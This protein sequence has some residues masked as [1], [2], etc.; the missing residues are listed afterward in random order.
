MNNYTILVVDDELSVLN[1]IYRLF[2]KDG[3]QILRCDKPADALN[4][5]K[6][7][8]IHIIISDYRMPD[9]DGVTFLREAM[10]L[11]PDTIRIILSGYADSSA[12]ISAINDGGIYKFLTKP[13]E[14]DMLRAEV[15]HALEFYDLR[16]VNKQLLK[17]IVKQNNELIDK[18]NLLTE[19]IE[20]I[21]ESIVSTVE[22]LNYLSREKY[23]AI[24]TNCEHLHNMS[25]KVGKKLG[26]NETALNHLHIATKLHDIGNI[27]VDCIILRKN[28]PLTRE[29]R[30]KVEKHPI[31]GASI[32]SFL[33]GFDEVSRIIRHHHEC[34]DGTGY[35]DGLKGDEIPI[36][37]R[38]I[39]II[40]V[41]DS[42]T[43]NR[44]YRSAMSVDEV[45]RILREGRG[46]NFD[47]NVLDIFVETIEGDYES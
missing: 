43:C 39:H 5:L 7:Q 30:K 1:A 41:Y 19:K 26:L 11:T 32:I 29:E 35:P 24:P 6:E 44:P 25:L 9:M 15:Q 8:L 22:M 2:R 47:P 10:T 23:T 42:L 20:E 36:V 4:I 3:Y 38:I 28:G 31:I 33:K 40:D 17:D 12:V 14:D 18:N 21:Q 34:F 45:Y 13:W 37:S 46:T 27:G 16:K